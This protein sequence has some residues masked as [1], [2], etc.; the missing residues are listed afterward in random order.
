MQHIES[1]IHWVIGIW[2]FE[3]TKKTA[4]LKQYFKKYYLEHVDYFLKKSEKNRINIECEVCKCILQ[5]K[6]I[7][8]HRL[9]KKHKLNEL[10]SKIMPS[11]A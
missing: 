6:N 4:D 11:S 5:K 1:K 2:F 3:K 9:T 7:S 10:N 8:A